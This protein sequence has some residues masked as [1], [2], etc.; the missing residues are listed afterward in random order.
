MLCA[1]FSIYYLI[2]AR[3]AG[4]SP[5][6]RRRPSGEASSSP[7]LSQPDEFQTSP[8]GEDQA[9]TTKRPK[10]T[11]TQEEQL[12]EVV[13]VKEEKDDDDGYD[14]GKGDGRSTDKAQADE[15]QGKVN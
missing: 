7:K 11:A 14:D 4:I 3:P 15:G 5:A 8:P 9:P 1:C 12:F 13:D 10:T 2:L 6:K